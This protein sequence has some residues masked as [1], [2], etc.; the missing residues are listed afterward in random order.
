MPSL[1]IASPMISNAT[2]FQLESQNYPLLDRLFLV[3]LHR[4]YSEA[5][6]LLGTAKN[7]M[8]LAFISD[9]R[10]SNEEVESVIKQ[11]IARWKL[12]IGISSCYYQQRS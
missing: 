2:Q 1:Q 7:A 5:V 8:E 11:C 6:P 10:M 3:E 4:L 9:D 12:E